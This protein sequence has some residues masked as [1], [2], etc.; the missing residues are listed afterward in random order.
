MCVS[1][2][3]DRQNINLQR[4]ALL[5][6]GVD[7]GGLHSRFNLPCSKWRRMTRLLV[8]PQKVEAEK[9]QGNSEMI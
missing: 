7:T 2:D 3:S 8:L 6:S 4:D 9:T 1:S 5:A